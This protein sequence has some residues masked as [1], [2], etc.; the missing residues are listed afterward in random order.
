MG[1]VK[2]RASRVI[3]EGDFGDGLEEEDD[4]DTERTAINRQT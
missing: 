1:K 4:V 3:E 2:L